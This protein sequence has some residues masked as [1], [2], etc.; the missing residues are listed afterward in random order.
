MPKLP[1]VDMKAHMNSVGESIKQFRM[2]TPQEVKENYVNSGFHK[3]FS[4][5]LA[6]RTRVEEVDIQHQRELM[7]KRKTP[8]QLS[9]MNHPLDIP[10]PKIKIP[11]ATKTNETDETDQISADTERSVIIF[12]LLSSSVSAVAA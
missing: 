4:Q 11:A 2:P 12:I 7:T 1:K 8:S 10:F 6:V 9:Q 3:Q 5:P